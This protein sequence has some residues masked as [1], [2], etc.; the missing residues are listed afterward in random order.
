MD[1]IESIDFDNIDFNDV[2][3]SDIDSLYDRDIN[4]D[5]D[6]IEQ[7]STNQNNDFFNAIN[8]IQENNK[9]VANIN[10]GDLHELFRNEKRRGAGGEVIDR[11]IIYG[12]WKTKKDKIKDL[13]PENTTSAMKNYKSTRK[14][15]YE[16][17]REN[18]LRRKKE[19][20]TCECGATLKRGNLWNHRTL[21]K[22]HKINLM[23]KYKLDKQLSTIEDMPSYI[24]N[25]LNCNDPPPKLIK[26]QK[27]LIDIDELRDDELI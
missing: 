21:S 10:I 6:I 13:V 23:D 26:K 22:S 27:V 1:P 24:L 4:D 15:Y 9:D 7:S 16:R 17:S 2:H 5:N 14:I 11:Q 3:F 19:L 18:I 8:E 20:V 25:S 12:L